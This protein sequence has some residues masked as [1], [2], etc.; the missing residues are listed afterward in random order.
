MRLGVLTPVAR[1]QAR[2]REGVFFGR[3]QPCRV[4]KPDLSFSVGQG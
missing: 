2:G 3:T 1:A 4:A